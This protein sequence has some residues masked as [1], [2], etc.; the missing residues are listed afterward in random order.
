MDLD[1][2]LSENGI[3]ASEAPAS[4][5][6]NGPSSPTSV[7]IGSSV[8]TGPVSTASAASDTQSNHSSGHYPTTGSIAVPR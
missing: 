5:Q 6:S 4:N 8:S 7:R 2:F 1:E 3:P